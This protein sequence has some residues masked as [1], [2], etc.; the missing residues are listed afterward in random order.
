MAIVQCR[1]RHLP[2]SRAR[3]LIAEEVFT[4]LY[5]FTGEFRKRFKPWTNAPRID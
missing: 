2:S 1:M 3:P 4:K 5:Y